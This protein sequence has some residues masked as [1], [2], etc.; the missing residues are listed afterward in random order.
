MSAGALLM[1]AG[2]FMTV[3]G[4]G[5]IA[6]YTIR[7]IAAISFTIGS[8]IFAVMQLLQTYNGNSITIRRLRRIH[9]FL[10]PSV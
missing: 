5:N 4:I 1:V 10:V 9:A 7:C 2:I 6:T 8:I 3:I